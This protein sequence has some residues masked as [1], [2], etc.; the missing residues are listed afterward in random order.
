MKFHIYKFLWVIILISIPLISFGQK[1]KV[2]F[3]YLL[4][5][6]PNETSYIELQF[7]FDGKGLEYKT[8]DQGGYQ[9]LMG[10][11]I[12]FNNSD[13]VI[14]RSYAFTSEEY[15]DS[16]SYDKNIY[17]VVRIPLPNGKFQMEIS[18][19]DKNAV[20]PDTLS[21]KDHLD[22]HYNPNSV[23][24]SDIMPIGFFSQATKSDNFTKH[25]IDYMPYFS[26]YYPENIKQLTF[27]TEIYYTDSVIS[28]KDF[29]IHSY[30]TRHNENTPISP[31]YERWEAAKKTDIHVIFQS[32]KI[33]SLPSGNYY[34]TIEVRDR[35][36]TL[37]AYTS[38]FFQRSN[39]LMQ[40]MDVARTDS[41]PYDTLKLYLD[42]IYIIADI[43][44][45]VFIDNISPEKYNE[46]EDFFNYF[47]YKRNKE[48]PHEAWY[49]YYN[50]VMRVNYNYSTLNYKGYK[51]DRGY[52]Y[53]KYGPPTDI[54]YEHSTVN[55]PPYE[56][57]TYNVLSDGQVNVMFVF[58]NADLTT[59]DFR[60]L[61][62][63]ARGELHNENWKEILYIKE[64]FDK[65]E[66]EMIKDE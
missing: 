48:N 25:G 22:I 63:T 65:G 4:F 62:S 28:G 46:I 5:H 34:L 14:K 18:L 23:G 32:F 12:S 2:N 9:A 59:K 21:F 50:Q 24:L 27:L 39:T 55:G 19:Y 8:T 17:N 16:L 13:T 36:D 40:N 49:R 30:I 64:G 11:N 44:E 35:K 20:N 3:N 43:E 60:L 56:I 31:Q 6:I 45:K 47:W 38:L 61:H 58:Y 51:T 15:T 33:D 53:L 1:F 10:T 29:V 7:L 52:Y 66:T 41:L 54:E 26:T 57:W 37:H 42:Y